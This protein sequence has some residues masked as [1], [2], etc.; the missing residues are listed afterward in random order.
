MQHFIMTG[1]RGKELLYAKATI[2]FQV[3]KY[4]DAKHEARKQYLL[5]LHCS[6]WRS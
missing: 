6:F 4:G 3:R 1:N 2:I 5:L